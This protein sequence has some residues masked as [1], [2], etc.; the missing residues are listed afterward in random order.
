MNDKKIIVVGLVMA[1]VFGGVIWYFGQDRINFQKNGIKDAASIDYNWIEYG[2]GSK[3]APVLMVEYFSYNCSHCKSF[4]LSTFP[5]IKE[6]YIDTG[7]IKFISRQAFGMPDFPAG[8]LCAGDQGK[9]WEYHDYL[10]QNMITISSKDDL[11]SIARQLNLNEDQFNQCFDS[12]KY[13]EQITQWGDEAVAKGV[14]G[15]PYFFVGDQ[16]IDGNVSYEKFERIIEEE[17]NK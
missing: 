16:T 4:Q 11:K 2:L 5:K 3:S 13:K 1:A 9:F 6:K 8:A 10:F 17:L 14:N 12:G 15:V 7:K